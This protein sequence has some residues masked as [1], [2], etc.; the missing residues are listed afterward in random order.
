MTKIEISK[1]KPLSPGDLIE[2][3]FRTY[4]GSW[5]RA[6]QL[7]LIEKKLEGRGDFQVLSW[8]LIATNGVAFKIKILKSNPVI[9]TAGIIGGIII[10]SGVVAWLTLDKVY[11]I[12]E[13]PAG[14]IGV[15]GT[16]LL[17]AA[18]AIAAIITLLPRSKK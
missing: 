10:A 2:M 3:Q 15:A 8:T 11:Q 14:Q 13:S 5:L 17:A 6:A 4:G 12:M 1:D 9:L 18:A 7:A 16:G